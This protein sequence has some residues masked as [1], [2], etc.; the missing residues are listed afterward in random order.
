MA[1]TA[2]QVIVPTITAFAL[3]NGNSTES[4]SATKMPRTVAEL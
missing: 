3:Q 2:Q 4:S 1:A